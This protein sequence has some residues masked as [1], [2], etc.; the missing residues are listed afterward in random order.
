MLLATGIDRMIAPLDGAL[1]ALELHWAVAA[2]D[3]QS[4]NTMIARAEAA[5]AR[6]VAGRPAVDPDDA[7]RLETLAGAYDLAARDRLDAVLLGGGDERGGEVEAQVAAGAGRAF[8]LYAV[9]PLPTGD[10][11]ALNYR[12]LHLSALAEIGGRR[13]D[14][15]RWMM[16][17]Q[18]EI[19]ASAGPHDPWDVELI[20]RVTDVWSE[21]L[22]RS[23]PSGLGR[24]MEILAWVREERPAR[25]AALLG[26]TGGPDAAR[27]KFYLFALYH[28]IDAAT[29]LT[30][31]LRHG[32]PADILRRLS[33]RFSLARAATSGDFT[34][35][36]LLSWLNA[37][38]LLVARRRTP[39]L[40]IP[41]VRE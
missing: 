9:L 40:E 18:T 26:R 37:A 28:L 23:G 14:W 7:E 10:A 25:E 36:A 38:A 27:L 8:A 29:D 34:L 12:I 4:R 13:Q 35:A 20:R 3:P 15:E 22:K 1:D 11:P 30:V 33:L 24:A 21:L 41:G 16:V 2:T 39:Q 6:L 19:A 31:Y 32:E 17:H 5:C